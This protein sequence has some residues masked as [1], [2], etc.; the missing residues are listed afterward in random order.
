MAILATDYLE[1]AA[2]KWPGKAAIA[3][4]KRQMTYGE[5]WHD[6]QRIAQALAVAGLHRQP[7]VLWLGREGR[8]VAASQG[9]ALSGNIYV[10][11]DTA[12]PL[13]RLLRLYGVLRPSAVI[14]GREYA[15]QAACLLERAGKDEGEEIPCLLV[16]EDIV[17][18]Q[19]DAA[20]RAALTKAKEAR[21]ETDAL[22]IIFTSGS[23][24]QPKGVVVSHQLICNQIEATTELFGLDETQVRA[25]QVPLYFTMGAYDDVYSVFATGG[26]L[27]LLSATQLMFPR[28]LMAL[29]KKEGV[30]TIFWVP[31]MLKSL[32]TGRALELPPEELP[33]LK[34]IAFAG[35]PMPL[36]IARALREAF[37]AATLVNRYG[38][39]ELGPNTCYFLPQEMGEL[40]SLPL[41]TPIRGHELLLLDAQGRAVRQSGE[42]GEICV[43]GLT[44]LGYWCDR[45]RTERAFVQNPLNPAYPERLYRTGDLARLEPDG[46]LTY[47][48]RNDDQIKHLGYRIELG[49][50][51]A[52][53]AEIPGMGLA[54]C[55]YDEQ[56]DA[57]VLFYMGNIQPRD[58]MQELSDALPRYMWPTRFEH[59]EEMPQ[60]ATGK[61]DKQALKGLLG[62]KS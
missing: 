62:R 22:C 49:E 30:N 41:G 44:A 23:T 39:T 28:K 57:L 24:G 8:N 47:A 60:T 45:E 46:S 58:I 25:G 29:L 20:G 21:L 7:V 38:A 11:L 26:R 61:L 50:I 2:A 53:V 43:R 37:P 13:R 36:A 42:I 15:Q 55:I 16:Y 34:F 52:A 54:A 35:E 32:V 9:V 1:R 12:T 56:A 31:S 4:E 6:A 51:E 19:E 59:L 5:L 17:A 27:L 33:P 3:D 14:V 48:S 40:K 10:P 18:S